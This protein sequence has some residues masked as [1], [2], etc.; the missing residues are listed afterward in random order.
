MNRYLDGRKVVKLAVMPGVSP[1]FSHLKVVRVVFGDWCGS[2][3]QPQSKPQCWPSVHSRAMKSWRST[4]FGVSCVKLLVA[5]LPELAVSK[6]GS[7]LCC[8]HCLQSPASLLHFSRHSSPD[9]AGL[10]I[11]L[12]YLYCTLEE[13]NQTSSL[14]FYSP[15]PSYWEAFITSPLSWC[16][17]IG[18]P[19]F[20]TRRSQAE[21]KSSG[22]GSPGSQWWDLK[23]RRPSSHPTQCRLRPVSH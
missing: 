22:E 16:C 3:W 8:F 15:N 18:Y 4:E 7:Y 14:A 19:Q 12:E 17:E 13:N 6:L 23:G 1:G 11:F 2:D 10:E 20:I 9:S 5:D 21:G